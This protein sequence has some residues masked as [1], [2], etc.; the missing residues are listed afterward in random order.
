[1]RPVAT[2]QAGQSP[3]RYFYQEANLHAVNAHSGVLMSIFRSVAAAVAV[4]GTVCLTTAAFAAQP[5]DWSGFYLG[6]NAGGN[7]GKS[8]ASTTAV[9]GTCGA[10]YILAARSAI[11]AAGAQSPYTSGFTGGIQGGYNLQFGN[12]VAGLELDFGYFRSAGSSSATAFALGSAFTVNSSIK[13]D[14]LLTARPRLGIAID[15][16][17]FYGTGGFAVA[18][19]KANWSFTD[20]GHA[21]SLETASA[22]AVKLGW[23][24]GGG[25]ESALPGNLSVGCGSRGPVNKERCRKAM[26]S[27]VMPTSS[28]GGAM[29]IVL[30]LSRAVRK[31]AA[32]IETRHPLTTHVVAVMQATACICGAPNYVFAADRPGTISWTG[33]YVGVNAGYGWGRPSSHLSWES[34]AS[35]SFNAPLANADY[36]TR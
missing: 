22:S 31:L 34:A 19:L 7:G 8:E 1:M 17:L 12:V 21:D 27:T 28:W 5:S 35:N 24:V 9:P 14:W 26:P 13:T 36:T 30:C 15:N 16:W 2:V 6:L 23:A 3:L 18:N 33:F 32:M 11:D 29:S 25:I 10:C 20:S 4:A